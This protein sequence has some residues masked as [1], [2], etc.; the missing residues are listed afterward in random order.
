MIRFGIVGASGIARKFES[1]IIFTDN[2]IITAVSA[3]NKETAEI[4]KKEYGV[5]FAYGSYLELAE[6]NEIDAVYIATPH[7]FHYEQAILFMK[8]K[9]HVLIEKSISVNETQL[10][11][12][13][14][15]AK[16]NNVLMMEA[17]WTHFLP[18]ARYVK[19]YI[20]GLGNLLEA[21]IDFG[22]DLLA[23][24]PKNR[25]LQPELAGGSILDVGV[26]PI[27]FY[28]LIQKTP[29][30]DISAKAT[31]TDTGVDAAV[32]IKI[33]DENNAKIYIKS[34]INK[35]QSNDARLIYE[36]GIIEMKD[37]SRCKELYIDGDR[38]DIDFIGEGFPHQIDSF[39]KTIENNQRENNIMN[40]EAS[41]K[42]M[43][44]MDKVRNLIGLKYPFE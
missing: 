4:Y 21:Y 10:L 24:N 14:Q 39:V 44:T 31:F 23:D 30:K 2:A 15:V 3:R 29:I 40:F 9:K 16:E 20:Q 28:H 8:H 1:D 13:I 25:I 22:Y 35:L 6:S 37:F 26:Y 11:E 36:D 43:R 34:S 32:D 33:I 7:N 42:C 18:S 38:I 19:D 12:M 17:M 27:S 41:L 5:P